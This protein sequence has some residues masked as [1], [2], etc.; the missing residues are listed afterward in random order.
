ME[1][2]STGVTIVVVL[3]IL[4]TFATLVY[5]ITKGVGAK[6]KLS[7]ADLL[8]VEFEFDPSQKAKV[9]DAVSKAAVKRRE[10]SPVPSGPLRTDLQSLDRVR[11]RRLLWVDDNPDNN[12]YECVALLE[13]GFVIA[14]ATTNR[15]AHRYL[16]ETAFDLV[17]TDIG[18]DARIDD[19]A[20]L[21]REISA[22]H[23]GLPVIVY[24]GDAA[25]AQDD[26]TALGATAVLDEAEALIATVLRTVE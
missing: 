23:P 7:F 25:I 21:V 20:A 22:A 10:R 8:H 3:V 1:K 18:R 15:A 4:L 5:A 24:T 6:S 13:S 11:L 26:M 17:I 14:T 12:L 19:G 2:L 9:V 16:D